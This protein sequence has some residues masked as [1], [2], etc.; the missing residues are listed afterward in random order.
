MVV[1]S[2]HSI[3]NPY[4]IYRGVLSTAAW[5]VS[6]CFLLNATDLVNEA[7]CRKA[8]LMTRQGDLQVKNLKNESD[9]KLELAQLSPTLT[10]P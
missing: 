3:W 10:F 9:S 1:E 4:G 5:C 7:P 2:T 6:D 8:E